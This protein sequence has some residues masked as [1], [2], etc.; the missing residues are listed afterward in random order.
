[1]LRFPRHSITLSLPL[2]LTLACTPTDSSRDSA[3]EPRGNTPPAAHAESDDTPDL[4]RVSDIPW[5]ELGDQREET[6]LVPGSW[7]RER[8]SDSYTRLEGSEAGRQLLDTIGAH[9]GLAAWFAQGPIEFRFRYGPHDEDPGAMIDSVQQIDTWRGFATHHLT[10]TPEVRFGWSEE[11]A[12]QTASDDAIGTNPR[13]WALTPYYFL[14]IPWVLADSGVQL[15][16]LSE[17]QVDGERFLTLRASFGEG[18]GDAPDDY[19]VLL[20]DPDTDRVRGV[21]YVV[22]YPGFYDEGEHS[23]EKVLFYEDY[24]ERNGLLLARRFHSYVWVDDDDGG[25][26]G[27]PAARADVPALRFIPELPNSAFTVPE[28]AELRTGY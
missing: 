4:T 28:D 6:A 26:P 12:W 11:G 10:S 1:M 7:I 3:P 5:A 21:R 23:P 24:R 19:Y 22:S 14:G 9:G 8:V 25:A 17:L 15:S 16:D 27:E 20:I 2:L 13:F 18:V